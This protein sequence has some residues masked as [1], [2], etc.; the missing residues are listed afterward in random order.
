[1]VRRQR[2]PLAALAL[3]LALAIAQ[4]IARGEELPD[5]P[6]VWHPT[7]DVTARL[8]GRIDTDALQSE[9]SAKNLADF[10]E[11][12]DAVGLRRARIGIEGDFAEGGSYIAEIDLA[13]GNVIIRDLFVGVPGVLD[14]QEQVGHF[15]EPFSLEG[16]TSARFFAFMERSPVNV[17]DP[18]RNW[19]VG[20]MQLEP[21]ENTSFAIGGFYGGPDQNDFEGGP[22][23]TTGVTMKLTA[24]PINDGEGSQLLH[25]GAALSERLPLDG[26]I[27]VNQN[28]RSPL[29]EFTDTTTSV[30]LPQLIIPADFQH[31][32]NA[33][34]ARVSGPWW[35]QTE[36]YGSFIE[37]PSGGA[38][39]YDGLYWNLGCFLTGEHRRYSA[40]TGEFG[41]VRVAR[42]ALSGPASRGRPLGAGAWEVA[43]RFAWID[44]FDT[45]APRDANG[46]LQGI[47][48]SQAT[49]GVNW[50]L[51]DRVRLMFNYTYAAPIEPTVGQSTASLFGTRLGVW[52]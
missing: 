22:G 42:P 44:F 8:R 21:T 39:F 3:G 52:W 25:F 36:W 35:T 9:Q 41:E 31:I 12:N 4:S 30:F 26:V 32:L 29:L 43:A 23:S 15:R 50:Y 38:V 5:W 40:A 47:E 51:T 28:P 46:E 18:A 34:I 14:G 10:G 11:L 20:L 49:L 27:I 33:Q 16:G 45:A 7:P 1:M 24:A 13:G 6:P 19:G 37:Q 17:L 2:I 48:M